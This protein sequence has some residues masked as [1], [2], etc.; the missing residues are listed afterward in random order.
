MGQSRLEKNSFHK[1][2]PM[3]CAPGPPSSSGITYSP[4]AGM[5]TSAS[6]AT[7]PGNDNGKVMVRNTVH[8]LA[9][10]SA[11]ASS[12]AGSMRDRRA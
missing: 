6:P 12:S 7:M 4:T 8:G 3:V 1:A 5:N 11:A 9:P 2:R 10:R